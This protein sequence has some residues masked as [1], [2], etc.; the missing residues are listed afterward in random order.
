MTPLGIAADRLEPID[1]AQLDAVAPLRVRDDA[2]HIVDLATA[3]TLVERLT[4]THRA[5]EIG[6]LRAF[7]YDTVYFDTPGF[8][9]LRD[10]VQQRRVRH[11]YRTRLYS[12]AGVCAFEIKRKGRRGETIKHRLAYHPADHG[13]LTPGARAFL[14]EHLDTVPDLAP[15]LRSTYTRLTFVAE[16]ERLTLDV[17]LAYGDAHLRPGW[18]IAEVKSASGAGVA[19]QAL[20]EL[21]SRPVSLSKYVVGAGMTRL[22]APPNDTRRI[23]RRY[24]AH[25]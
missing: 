20:R 22:P 11:K 10:H 6:G 1:L 15:V 2:K 21:G 14:A 24:F 13:T 25:A 18:A 23:V 8:D 7:G 3:G 17:D 16:G 12:D 5:L 9:A 19:A 4:A